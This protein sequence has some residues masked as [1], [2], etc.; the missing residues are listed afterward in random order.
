MN[1]NPVLWRGLMSSKKHTLKV[2]SDSGFKEE[3]IDLLEIAAYYFLKELDKIRPI[4]GIHGEIIVVESVNKESTNE[5]L[6]GDMTEIKDFL[7]DNGTRK[8]YYVCR[9]ADCHNSAETMRTLAHELVHVW[10][11]ELGRLKLSDEDGWF[12]RGK[13]Y[14]KTPYN[15][16]DDDF[17]LPWEAEAD[18]LDIQLTKKFYKQYFNTGKI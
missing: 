18:I 13:S 14:G 9:L 3:E 7:L 2:V 16:T 8:N 4:G 5:P 15:G 17:N 6:S 12:W 11:T 1:V 10:Q